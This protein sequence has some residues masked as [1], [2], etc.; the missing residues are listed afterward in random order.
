MSINSKPQPPELAVRVF[1]WYC[2]ADRLEELEGDLEELF[3]SRLRKGNSSWNAKLFFWW[4]VLRCYRAYSKSQT[5]KT[6]NTMIPLF[7]SYFKLALRHSWKNKGP[8]AINIVGLGV[9]LSMCM[10]VY[11]LYAFNLEYDSFYKDTG[12][13]Y[14]VHAVT[15][16]NGKEKRNEF[17]PIALDDK[18]RNEISGINQVSSYFSEG[19]TIKKDSEFFKERLGVASSDFSEMF[20]LPLWYG[21][22]AEFGNKPVVYLTKPLAIK[23]FGDKVAL[24]EKLTLYLTDENKIEVTV[25]GVFEKIPSNS[26]FR[27]QLLISQGDYL[28]TLK[29]DPNDWSSERLVGHYLNL[30][31]LQKDRITSEINRHIAR[32]N[33]SRK[34]LRIKRFELVPFSSPMPTDLI[35]GATY[36]GRRAG[37]EVLIIFTTLALMVFLIACFNLANTSMALIARRLKEIGIRKTLG[38]GKNQILIQFLFEMSIVSFFAFI[39]AISTANLTSKSIMGLFGSS[40]LLQDIDLIGIILFVAGFLVF[41]TLVAGLLPALYAWK[42]QPVAIMRKSVKLKGINWLNKGLTIAQYSFSIV[43]LMLGVTFSQNADFLSELDLGYQEEGI[44][45]IPIENEYFTQVKGEV[46]QLPGVVT[47]GATNH[48][49][50]FGQYSRQVSLQIDTSLHEVRYYAVGENYL[51]LM[52]V[53]IVAGRNFLKGGGNEKGTILVSQSFANQYF[54]GENPINKVVK[55][56]GERKTIVGIT[57]DVIDDVVKAAELLPTVVALSAEED[58]RHLIV[59][60]SNEDLNEVEDQ[61]KTIWKQYIDQPYTGVLQA[62]FAL[63]T[64]GQESKNLQKVFLVMASL[65]GLLSIIGIFS[66]A[67]LNVAK[68]IKEISIR[69]VLGSSLSDLLLTINKSFTITLVL[70]LTLGTGLGYLITNAVLDLIYKYHVEASLL[71]SLLSATFIIVVS[72]IMISSIALVP[73]NSNPING[74]K[75]E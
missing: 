57:V 15:L 5:Q 35:I 67:K 46:D 33:E 3:Y 60:T 19:I 42:F 65:S 74:L 8:V 34:E 62:D 29:I 17:S 54:E 55:I 68:R 10:F 1:R 48:L 47:A 25:G 32:Q 64:A 69:K 61:I 16:H 51:D 22:F 6:P 2:N 12:N 37:T 18:L 44:F 36:V 13:S 14:R 39:I 71:T 63:G 53:R 28:R 56:E 30:S 72:L 58:F 9:A 59:R 31:A 21:S 38:S 66:L 27:F 23:Y 49:G 70:A 73:A 24:G 26:S 41:T 43:V 52:E 40:F 20:E 75:D 11:M 4:N 50:N 45:D 7:K